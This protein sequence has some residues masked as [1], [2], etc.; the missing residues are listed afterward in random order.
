M[1]RGGHISWPPV[2]L[3]LML[4]DFVFWEYI[5]SAVYGAIG[6]VDSGEI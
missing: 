1:E 3:N 2:P 4:L 5:K 6:Y